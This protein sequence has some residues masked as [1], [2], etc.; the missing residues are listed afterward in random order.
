[1]MVTHSTIMSEQEEALI[2]EMLMPKNCV[3]NE[4]RKGASI[5]DLSKQFQVPKKCVR[6]RLDAMPIIFNNTSKPA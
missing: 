4:L 3:A 5:N 2:Y 6:E 1:M